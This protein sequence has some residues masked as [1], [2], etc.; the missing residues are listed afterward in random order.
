MDPV[1]ARAPAGTL[2]LAHE[3]AFAAPLPL[4]FAPR[5]SDEHAEHAWLSPDDALARLV[6]PGLRRAV[7][8]AMARLAAA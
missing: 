5:L 3:T 2:R 7:R 4:G 1:L 6:H 8:L